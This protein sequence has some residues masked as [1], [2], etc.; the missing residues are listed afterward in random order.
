[1]GSVWNSEKYYRVFFFCFFIFPSVY[2]RLL[3]R[4]SFV[5]PIRS[6]LV[7]FGQVSNIFGMLSFVWHCD[8]EFR[9]WSLSIPCRGQF[10]WISIFSFHRPVLQFKLNS[11]CFLV[12]KDVYFHEYQFFQCMVRSEIHH[13]SAVT[14]EETH[15]WSRMCLHK[16]KS[17]NI[18]SSC[19]FLRVYVRT[20]YGL[21][22]L[23]V[24]GIIVMYSNSTNIIQCSFFR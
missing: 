13:Y 11:L 12:I 15:K 9:Q 23:C 7:K 6:I 2:G 18:F 20:L 1:M 10:V 22:K 4:N 17:I 8:P 16:F 24:V 21:I 14:L 19:I 5:H 3:V